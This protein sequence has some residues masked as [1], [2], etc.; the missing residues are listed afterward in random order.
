[1]NYG[2]RLSLMAEKHLENLQLQIENGEIV[3]GAPPSLVRNSTSTTGMGASFSSHGLYGMQYQNRDGNDMEGVP[4][5]SSGIPG[6]E[7]L[8]E[9]ALVLA[10]EEMYEE[11]GRRYRPWAANGRACRVGEII[12]IVDSDTVVPEVR[13]FCSLVSSRISIPC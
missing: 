7:D 6:D 10:I 13:D 5:G 2:L 8:E 1:M 11:S 9:K 4:S 3:P 12:L